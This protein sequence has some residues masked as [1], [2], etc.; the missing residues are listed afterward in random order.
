MKRTLSIAVIF[1][2]GLTLLVTAGSLAANITALSKDQLKAELNQ[3]E[4]VVIDVRPTF[5][6]LLSGSKIPTAVR[7]D[8]GEVPS[9]ITK[10]DKDQPIVLYCQTQV[11]SAGV[12]GQLADAGFKKVYVLHGGWHEWSKARYPTAKK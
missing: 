10:Y 2:M 9:W 3:S 4:M 5:S 7:E 6:W 11:T 8:P 12:A 1:S